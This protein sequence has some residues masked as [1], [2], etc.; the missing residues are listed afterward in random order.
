MRRRG[1]WSFLRDNQRLLAILKFKFEQSGKNYAEIG[2]IIGVDRGPVGN[3]FKGKKPNLLDYDIIR[4]AE[5][6]GV[7]ISLDIKLNQ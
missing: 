5:Y 2:E 1:Q 4:I 7:S 3:Y 6:L